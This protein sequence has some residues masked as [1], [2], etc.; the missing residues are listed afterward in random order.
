MNIRNTIVG[1]LQSKKAQLGW[2]EMQYFFYGFA[3]GLIGGIVVVTLS[4]KKIIPFKIAAL[5]G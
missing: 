1:L 4:C 3:V 2:I 5:C